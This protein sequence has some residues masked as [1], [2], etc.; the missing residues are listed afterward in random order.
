MFE[1]KTQTVFI[2]LVGIVCITFPLYHL[3]TP[4]SLSKGIQESKIGAY[5]PPNADFD[6]C[7]YNYE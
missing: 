3:N 5:G 4:E 2:I 1:V 6:W 7:E